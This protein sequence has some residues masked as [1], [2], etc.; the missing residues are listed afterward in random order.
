M[1]D[2]N[3]NNFDAQRSVEENPPISFEPVPAGWYPTIIT[4]AEW[5]PTN[6]QSGPGEML[7]LTASI[8]DGEYKGKRCWNNLNLK[9][10]SDTAVKIAKANLGQ[11]AIAIGT[12]HPKHESEL[13]NKP[14]SA[15]WSVTPESKG[16]P[17]KNEVK[18]WKPLNGEKSFASATTEPISGI[19]SNKKPWE[20]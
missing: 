7:V 19:V 8:I 15:Y 9:N 3:W 20:K 11:L 16:Y 17:A 5:K 1:S 6:G 12:L 13:L 4:S 10:N 2:F 14:T 18:E